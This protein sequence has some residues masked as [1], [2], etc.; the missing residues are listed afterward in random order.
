[1]DPTPRFVALGASNLARMALTLLDA[2]R[3]EAGGAV[4]AHAA[5]GRGRSYGVRSRLF[6]RVLRGIDGCELW[7]VLAAAPPRPTLALVMDV[8]NDLL[9]GEDV[10]RILAWVEAALQRLC[11]PTTRVVVVGLPLPALRSLTPWRFQV[12]RTLLVP[13]SRLSLPQVLDLAERL[14]A[15]LA[16]LAANHGARFHAPP[17]P[18]YGFDPVHVRPVRWPDAA[19]LWLDTAAAPPTPPLDGTLAR[20]RFL[21]AVPA[22]RS[23]LGR[24]QRAPQPCRRWAD[25][26]TLSLW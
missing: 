12:M 7:N 20:L 2:A 23:L 26:T 18:W 22:Q 25:G 3:A 13:G 1:M 14:H 21:F 15:G 8:G 24:P 11:A 16:A 5:L 19:R 4:E 6:G 9:Y 10:P 17:G